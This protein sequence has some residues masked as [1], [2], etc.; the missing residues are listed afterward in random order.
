MEKIYYIYT[1][2]RTYGGSY[3]GTHGTYGEDL[4]H[5]YVFRQHSSFKN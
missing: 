3:G 5:L 4:L 2:L 1:F